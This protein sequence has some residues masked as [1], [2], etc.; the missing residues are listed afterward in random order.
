MCCQTHL[1]EIPKYQNSSECAVGVS[2]LILQILELR[3]CV[4]DCSR[5]KFS[6]LTKANVNHAGSST[7]N[8]SPWVFLVAEV[9]SHVITFQTGIH[10]CGS[11]ELN[12]TS[13]RSQIHVIRSF[14]CM[15]QK[16]AFLPKWKSVHQYY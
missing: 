15:F 3:T 5:L 7:R 14:V 11:K 12:L 2:Y 6:F 9:N 8:P 16:I 1:P 13:I 4:G 10:L